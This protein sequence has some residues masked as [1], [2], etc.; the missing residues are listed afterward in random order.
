MKRKHFYSPSKC[1]QS[2]PCIIFSR[3]ADSIV[4]YITTVF[5]FL[6][7]TLALHILLFPPQVYFYCVYEVLETFFSLGDRQTLTQISLK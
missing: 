5:F 7:L 2:I 6:E 3:M 4:R 1:G